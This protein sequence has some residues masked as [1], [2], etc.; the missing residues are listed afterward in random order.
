[1]FPVFSA[2]GF[3]DAAELSLCATSDLNKCYDRVTVPLTSITGT[4]PDVRVN[5]TAPYDSG[6]LTALYQQINGSTTSTGTVTAF[7]RGWTL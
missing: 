5:L 6:G 3:D 7:V 1:L 4:G 2:T